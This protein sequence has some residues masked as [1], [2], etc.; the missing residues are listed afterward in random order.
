MNN[1]DLNFEQF[2]YRLFYYLQTHIPTHTHVHVILAITYIDL[3]QQ[4]K[5]AI[6]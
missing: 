2:G 6:L 4:G 5:Y 1:K 3:T